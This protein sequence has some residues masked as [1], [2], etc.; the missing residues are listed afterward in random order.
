MTQP[1]E[2]STPP[3]RLELIPL[4]KLRLHPRARKH[5]PDKLAELTAS[6]KERGQL[7][8]AC[9][10]PKEGNIEVYIGAGRFQACQTLGRPLKVLIA[11]K[12]DEDVDVDMLHE[13]LKREELNPIAEAGEYKYFNG[14]KG[15]SHDQIAEK[16]GK[17][18]TYVTLSLG[19]LKLPEEIQQAVT[20]GT[21][22]RSLAEAL[23]GLKTPEKQLELGRKAIKEGWSVRK[24]EVEVAKEQAPTKTKAVAPPAVQPPFHPIE[25]DPVAPTPAEEEPWDGICHFTQD[26]A[27]MVTLNTFYERGGDPDDLGKLISSELSEWLQTREGSVCDWIWLPETEE[28][29]REFEDLAANSSGPGPLCAKVFIKDPY[30]IHQKEGVTWDDIKQQNPK[31]SDPRDYAR[32]MV[33]VI[34]EFDV[35]SWDRRYLCS[36]KLRKEQPLPSALKPGSI[37]KYPE[38]SNGNGSNGHH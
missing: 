8:P 29:M 25:K 35:P 36:T 2:M 15:W 1:D 22:P 23:L 18:K 20:R 27:N 21:A 33:E 31:K 38:S 19:L 32:M 12:S 4:D 24:T 37:P 11:E 9:G 3:E 5:D 26:G 7:E 6:I 17:S 13:N 14:V 34:R 10:R 28:E 16:V 30:K